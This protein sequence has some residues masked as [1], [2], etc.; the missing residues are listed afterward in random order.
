M[1]T[2]S[3]SWLARPS[4]VSAAAIDD[5]AAVEA[6]LAPA[7]HGVGPRRRACA[8]AARRAPRR[9]PAAPSWKRGRD[10]RRGSERRAQHQAQGTPERRRI[11]EPAP[12]A[13]ID[14]AAHESPRRGARWPSC[15]VVWASWRWRRRR[16]PRRT[17][18][19]AR[20][21][22]R[23]RCGCSAGRRRSC[24]SSRSWRSR[25]CGR[26]RSCSSQHRRGCSSACPPRG[27]A[28]E[29]PRRGA[30]RTRHL[31]R[32][33]RRAGYAGELLGDVHLRH[34]LGRH[35]RRERAVRRRLP[36]VQP[37][38]HV[39]ARGRRRSR[40]LSAEG[41]R[42]RP[43]LRY[44]RVAGDVAVGR[45][46]RRLRV[47][48]AR[49]RRNATSRDARGAVARL[50]PGDAPRDDAVRGRGVGRRRPTGSAPTSTCSRGCR[51]SCAGR[52]RRRS[53]CAGR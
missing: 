9:S 47:A 43:P 15:S 26:R 12:A 41:G 20:P 27:M 25:R 2:N 31:Q 22:C 10:I 39:R 37:V 3:S 13:C 40:A 52:G 35:A 49:L 45:G 48:G 4:E 18:S 38:A 16:A 32:L 51:R 23:S 44:P 11:G 24:S 8:R 1:C 42:T 19:S 28:G 33:R 6:R 17:G 30:V 29:P 5:E 7:W 36:R 21:T 14:C 50:L 53:A 46:D 34:L